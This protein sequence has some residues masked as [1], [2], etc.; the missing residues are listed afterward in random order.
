MGIGSQR[1]APVDLP[2]KRDPVPT[3]EEGMWAHGWTGWV[4]KILPPPNFL[5]AKRSIFNTT[6]DLSKYK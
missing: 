6:L 1:Q 3:I 4:R 5:L 2:P